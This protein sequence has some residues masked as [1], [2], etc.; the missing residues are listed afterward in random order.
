MPLP[1]RYRK[2]AREAKARTRLQFNPQARALELLADET[3]R[4]FGDT[5]SASAGVSRGLVAALSQ[6]PAALD[7]LYGQAGLTADVRQNLNE[8]PFQRR[9][10]TELASAQGEILERQNQARSGAAFAVQNAAKDYR[11]DMRQI[12][13][14]RLGLATDRGLYRETLLGDLIGADKAARQEARMARDAM[15]FDSEQKALDRANQQITS[16]IGQ[17]IAPDGSL[18]PGGDADADGNGKPGNQKKDRPSVTAA[19]Q[20]N[21]GKS[22]RR[23]IREAKELLGEPGVT[24]REILE[25]LTTDDQGAKAQPVYETVTDPKTG[26][27]TQRRVLN[28]D[29]TPKMTGGRPKV[30]AYDELIARAAIEIANGGYISKSTIRKL[31][32]AGYRPG[33]TGVNVGS[34][35]Q[36]R[37]PGDPFKPKGASG[38]SKGAGR[39]D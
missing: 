13:Q 35:K 27:K 8:N 3:T 5:V 16:L 15:L 18:I 21:F 9:Q 30:E 19:E 31:R 39:P 28:P 26:K 37:R 12:N 20:T 10:A 7:A 17:G 34:R 2:Y 23:A 14:Q 25:V 38:Y 22:L 36:R 29:G 24:P 1:R 11:Q 33:Q 6:Q 32:K 4:A